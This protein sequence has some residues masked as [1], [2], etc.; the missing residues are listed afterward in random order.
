M[1]FIMVM[2]DFNSL[3]VTSFACSGDCFAALAMTPVW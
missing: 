2:R 1:G 3:T